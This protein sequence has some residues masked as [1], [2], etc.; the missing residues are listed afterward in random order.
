MVDIENTTGEATTETVSEVAAVSQEQSAPNA[1]EEFIGETATAEGERDQTAEAE[2]ATPIEQNIPTPAETPKGIKGRI[3]AETA[4]A[5]KA[6]YERGRAE[7]KAEYD[8]KFAEMEKRIS[9]YEAKEQEAS[10]EAQA[11]ELARNEHCTVEFAKR[12][13]MAE[14]RAEGRLPKV[15]ATTPT[16][17]ENAPK[18][19]YSDALNAR[20]DMLMKQA[21][22]IKAQ[23]GID[24]LE[25]MKTDKEVLDKV[26]SEEW[27]FR[28]VAMR[29]LNAGASRK[30]APKPIRG[31]NT[32][33]TA[34]LDIMHMTD[35]QFE[36]FNAR[37]KEGGV[38]RPPR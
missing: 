29:E 6:G 7:L 24:C 35:E 14:A 32:S 37:L 19:G 23:Y 2:A 34:G 5:D 4:K 10:I 18:N 15:A 27:D 31:S 33:G 21:E 28:D 9:A 30:T 38:Y 36:K 11:R 3:A 12:T 8:A 26:G 17:N 20:A 25:L 16:P 22:D 1:L 13:L